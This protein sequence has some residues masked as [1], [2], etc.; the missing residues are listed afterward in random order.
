[1]TKTFNIDDVQILD[2]LDVSVDQ[3]DYV[4][5]QEPLP[6][7]KGKYGVRIKSFDLR[8]VRDSEELQLQDGKYPIITLQMLEIADAGT[9]TAMVGRQVALYQDIYTKPFERQDRAS[10]GTVL[11]NSLGDLVRSADPSA[12]FSGLKEGISLLQSLVAQGAVFYFDMDWIA[13]DNGASREAIEELET[14]ANQNG[15][16]LNSAAVR[17]AR[18]EVYKKFTRRGMK[19]FKNEAGVIVPFILST[20]GDEIPARVEIVRNGFIP[21]SQLGKVKLGPAR[22]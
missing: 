8:R 16:D 17:A 5:R 6:L 18:N 11:V 15:E 21:Q 19:N 12:S 13:R 7:T 4:E 22:V 3:N 2:D 9:E 14:R 20:T 10:G 1:M